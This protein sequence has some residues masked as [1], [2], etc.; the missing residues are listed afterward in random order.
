MIEEEKMAEREHTRDFEAFLRKKEK[1][2]EGE[3]DKI[4]KAFE[5]FRWWRHYPDGGRTLYAEHRAFDMFEDVK[6][7][8]EKKKHRI[9]G[10]K[11]KNY[12]T[13]P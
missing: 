5:F 6:K 4:E 3:R 7:E 11:Q 8:K 2:L 9:S 13:P 1:E 12:Y 10:I